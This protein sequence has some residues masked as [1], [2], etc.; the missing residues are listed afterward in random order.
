ME[1][2]LEFCGL[3]FTV[4]HASAPGQGKTPLKTGPLMTAEGEDLALASQ[5]GTVPSSGY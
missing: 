3:L 5:L 2:V 4:P 1:V